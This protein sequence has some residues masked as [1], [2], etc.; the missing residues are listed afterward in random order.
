MVRYLPSIFILLLF[1]CNPSKPKSN[2]PAPSSDDINAIIK[3]IV[4]HD[5]LVKDNTP[6]SIDLRK[7]K[8]VI[9]GPNT[10]LPEMLYHKVS[11]ADLIYT[12]HYRESFFSKTDSLY[13][14]FQNDT[15]K[16]FR[17]NKNLINGIPL[18]S[19]NKQQPG[20]K[21]NYNARFF[22]MSIPIFSLDQNTAYVQ[23]DHICPMCGAGYALYLQKKNGEWKIVKSMMTWLN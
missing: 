14:L 11:I 21:R 1:A 12:G 23:L 13:L 6:L 5:S 18:T 22:D 20:N 4:V 10:K 19:T 8:I 2:F 9:P 17:F 15:L 7:I 16:S 3:A